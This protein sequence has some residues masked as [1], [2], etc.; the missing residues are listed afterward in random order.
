M[1]R[2]IFDTNVYGHLLKEPDAVEIEEKITKEK[3]LLK[4]FRELL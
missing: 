4:K 1:L 2:V 3:D